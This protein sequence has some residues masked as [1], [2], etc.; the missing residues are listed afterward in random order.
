MNKIEDLIPIAETFTSVQGEGLQ[1]G[2]RMTFFRLAGCTV[3]KRYPREHY[4][5]RKN[6]L[7]TSFTMYPSY[8][9]Q[10]TAFDG[11]HFPCDTNY[12]LAEKVSI[13]DLIKRIP[14]GV[15]WVSITGGEPLMHMDKVITLMKALHK[16]DYC[17]H[18]ETSGTITI[19]DDVF[20]SEKTFIAISPKA[21]YLPAYLFMADEIRLMVDVDFDIAAAEK[22]IEAYTGQVFLCPLSYVDDVTKISRGSMA[23]CLELIEMPA[24]DNARISI[25]IHKLLGC[26]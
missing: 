1:V 9:N 12:N 16:L 13:D 4:G 6:D 26:R 23:K 24:F 8:V 17:V 2:M 11:R 7:P 19:E 14:E 22:C 25:Q 18:I 21:N 5:E 20:H 15:K 10:C 3:G